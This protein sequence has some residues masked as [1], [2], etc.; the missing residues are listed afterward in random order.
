VP[1]A[2]PRVALETSMG[3]IVLE[4]Y[5][6]KAPLTVANFLSYVKD[7]HYNG[8]IFHRVIGDF[9]IQ[10]GAYTPD[11]QQKPERAPVANEAAN[12]LS[13]LRGTLAAARRA[14]DATSATSQFFINTVD[15]RQ[16]DLRGDATAA[17][18]GFCVFG[19]VVEAWTWSIASASCPPAEAA[20][21]RRRAGDAGAG[22]KRQALDEYR[23]NH[24][25]AVRL[26]PAPARARPE[27]TAL[28]LDF[29]RDEAAQRRCA[30]HPRRPVR[31]LA[32]RRCR[33]RAGDRLREALS[34]LRAGGVPLYLMRGNRDFLFGPRFAADSGAVLLPDPCVVRLYGEPT[35]LMHGDL[36]CSDDRAYLAFRAQ[37]RNPAWQEAFLAMPLPERAGYAAQA[38]AASSERQAGLRDQGEL[39]QITDVNADTVAATMARF[40]VRRMIHGHTHRPAMHSLRVNGV[41]AQ[42]IVLGD[43]YEQGSVLRVSPEG[44]A[45]TSLELPAQGLA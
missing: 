31:G 41:P 23:R 14:T 45:L 11:M 12:G 3:R 22:R 30:V 20:A 17:L 13:N 34:R 9:L 2:G 33:R 24:D 5:P 15:N 1:V 21:R 29:L 35:L 38:R 10:G 39:E 7:G 26:R 40:G 18:A 32:G 37:V 6:D 16:L 43:W 19:R 44:Y 25:H 8:T 36:L 4:L 42:R 28:F 27:I